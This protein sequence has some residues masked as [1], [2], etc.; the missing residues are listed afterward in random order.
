MCSSKPSCLSRF[1][2]LFL[3]SSRSAERLP[4]FPSNSKRFLAGNGKLTEWLTVFASKD[5]ILHRRME[6]D[7]F[8][9]RNMALEADVCEPFLLIHGKRARLIFA[10]FS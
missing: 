9:S 10:S 1:P 6:I 8:D 5:G 7:W 2:S 4:F 3:R